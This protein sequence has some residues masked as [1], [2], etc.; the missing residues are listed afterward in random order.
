[1]ISG[2]ISAFL[3]IAAVFG[4][5]TAAAGDEGDS[6]SGPE[7]CLVDVLN[8]RRTGS[9][10]WSGMLREE[11]R[12]HAAV[13]A[14]RDSLGHGGMSDRAGGLPS[15]WTV[16]GETASVASLSSSD[17]EGIETW[18]R[19]AL[20]ALW[21]STAHR[22]ILSN[23]DHDFVSA[24]VYW[25]GRDI[26]IA[27][28]VFA[29]PSYRP[30]SVKWPGSYADGL[31]GGWDGRFLDDDASMFESDIEKLAASGVTL[32]CNPPL[33]TTFCPDAAVSRGE[34]AAFIA[35]SLGWEKEGSDSFHDDDASVF[36]DDIEALAAAGVTEGCNPPKRDRFCPD[37]KVTR[38]EMATFL[39]RALGLEPSASQAFTDISGSVH[40]HN[41]TALAEAG[42]TVGCD[43]SGK[44]FCPDAA[45]TRGQMAAFLVRAGL[46]N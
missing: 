1:M 9:L 18:C 28:G 29:H 27:I 25:D 20:D 12:S 35:R 11:L 13:M 26:W 10:E 34:M 41:I 16:Y 42:I 40:R 8:Q 43:Q 45:V 5:A 14:A 19:A 32:G 37:R 22:Q 2:R 15:G 31:V 36:E 30:A 38:A 17:A 23:G 4:P 6:P 44:R 3:L 24:G 46:A 33:N 21:A 7:A 39:G